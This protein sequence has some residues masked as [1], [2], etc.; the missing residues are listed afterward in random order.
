MRER[1]QST[2]F[3]PNLEL[4]GFCVFKLE[5]LVEA[6]VSTS[7]FGGEE[8]LYPAR[9]KEVEVVSAHQ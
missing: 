2:A 1:T 7:L 4:Q 5:S 9:Q 3:A 8:L 6:T